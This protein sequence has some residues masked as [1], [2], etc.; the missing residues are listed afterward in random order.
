MNLKNLV[1]VS[2]DCIDIYSY[3]TKIFLKKKI[4]LIYRY[5]MYLNVHHH[6]KNVKFRLSITYEYISSISSK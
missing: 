1:Y 3:E 4:I 2:L 6:I 5:V